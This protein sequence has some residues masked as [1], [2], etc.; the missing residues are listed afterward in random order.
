MS[1]E[2]KKSSFRV[3]FGIQYQMLTAFSLVAAMAVSSAVIA[4]YS[5]SGNRH[6]MHEIVNSILPEVTIAQHLAK[7]VKGFVAYA[8]QFSQIQSV[9]ERKSLENILQS[10]LNHMSQLLENLERINSQQK[11]ESG[12]KKQFTQLNSNFILQNQLS[13]R[14]IQAQNQLL[15][16]NELLRRRHQVFIEIAKPRIRQGY[17]NFLEQ[18]KVIKD[19]IRSALANPVAQGTPEYNQKLDDELR[20]G[21]ETMISMEVGEMRANLEMVATT[22][23]AAGLLHETAS[24][25]SVDRIHELEKQFTDILK[26]VKKLRL[27]L[28]TSTPEN[29]KVLVTAMP[30][31][32]FGKGENSIFKL[33]LAELNTRNAALKVAK[34]NIYLSEEL[35]LSVERMV[36]NANH[37]VEIASEKLNISLDRNRFLQIVTAILAV[38]ITFLIG[39]FFVGNRVVKRIQSLRHAMEMQAEGI[40]TNIPISGNDEISVMAKA[41]GKFVTQ[42]RNAEIELRQAKETAEKADKAKSE[43]LAN[44][45]HELRTPLNAVTGFSE[46]LSAVVSDPKQ[47]SY[48]DAIKTSGKS[49]LILINDILDLS[50]IEAGKMD[51]QLSNTSLAHLFSE[52]DQIFRIKLMNKNVKFSTHIDDALPQGLF[53]DEIRLRQVLFNLVGNAVK[54]TEKGQIQLTAR[55]D[56]TLNNDGSMNLIIC[57]SDTGMGISKGE[58]DNIFNPFEQQEG[59]SQEKFGGTGLGLSICRKLIEMMNGDIYLESEQGKGSVFTCRLKYVK[60]SD[61]DIAY[62][63]DQTPDHKNIKLGPAKILMDSRTSSQPDDGMSLYPLLAD[64]I[65]KSEDL[66]SHLNAQ[67]M[68]TLRKLKISLIIGSVEILG[69]EL[70]AI[71]TA[72]NCEELNQC[73]AQLL[74]DAELFEIER[75]KKCIDDLINM[76]ES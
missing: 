57:V 38:V 28:S 29:R 73:A 43:F 22:Y 32:A 16:A 56:E 7:E 36:E 35:E 17:H 18:G 64:K 24:I 66:K 44:M 5:V 40:D 60:I 65:M 45:S 3:K 2:P 61:E 12:L 39:W 50:K 70:D 33:R 74:S 54:F 48:L 14:F 11:N 25:D 1:I 71:G 55:P 52:I 51:I 27:I 69:Q 68:S 23:L 76:I 62:R 63:T 58:Q 15:E 34:E 41:L 49:L 19:K 6:R 4:L 9:L 72:F 10:K 37:R 31:L 21:L 30:I 13:N 75:I 42:R 46:L 20:I 47:Q 53:I 26:S 59:Q 67:V 8:N